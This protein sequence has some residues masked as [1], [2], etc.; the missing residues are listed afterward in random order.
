M[1]PDACAC[2]FASPP[3]TAATAAGDAA[4]EEEDEEDGDE[5]DDTRVGG[6]DPP[7][8]GSVLWLWL[9]LLPLV[10]PLSASVAL[11]ASVALMAE[12]AVAVAERAS[13]TKGPM[14]SPRAG[15]PTKRWILRAKRASN[16][17]G[18]REYARGVDAVEQ[19]LVSHLHVY[20]NT[21][22]SLHMLH[23][24]HL[25]VQHQHGGELVEGELLGAAGAR[26]P[27]LSAAVRLRQRLRG[28]VRLQ[29][30]P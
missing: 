19:W 20:F 15:K 26:A 13:C 4:A 17:C 10:L 9:L 18:C 28:R 3:S 22:R 23:R 1:L 12:A 21:I 25:Q 5:D 6:D 16:R 29:A 8:V 7:A 24:T 30:L 14:L 27:A 2:G 11:A